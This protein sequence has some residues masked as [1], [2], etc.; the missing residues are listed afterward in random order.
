MRGRVSWLGVMVLGGLFGGGCCNDRPLYRTYVRRES[1]LAMACEA[2]CRSAVVRNEDNS[3]YAYE[4][5]ADVTDEGRP[6][7]RCTLVA[8]YCTTELH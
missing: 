7:V 4:S 1:E 8:T 6:A 2:V 3:H 5:C